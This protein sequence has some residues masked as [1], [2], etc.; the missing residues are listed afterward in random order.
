MKNKQRDRYFKLSELNKTPERKEFE[1]EYSCYIFSLRP[2]C[3]FSP[4]EEIKWTIDTWFKVDKGDMDKVA[5]SISMIKMRA[6]FNMASV[7]G[8]WL[9]KQFNTGVTDNIENPDLFYDIIL[10]YKFKI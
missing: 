5:H 7:F 2:P 3:S 6:R 4:D 1:K 10:K 8:V 9:P